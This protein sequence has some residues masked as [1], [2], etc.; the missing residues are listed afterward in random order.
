MDQADFFLPPGKT[1]ECVWLRADLRLVRAAN[2]SPFTGAGTNSYLIGRGD[3][4]LVDPGPDLPAHAAALQA[5]LTPGERIRHVLVTHAHADHSA[6]ATAITA[7]TGAE[8][9]AFGDAH[10]GRSPRMT[11]FADVAGIGGGEGVDLTFQPDRCL[12]DGEVVATDAGPVT[13]LHM[14]GHMS[15]HLCFDW[16]GCL[17]TGDHVMGWSSSIVSPPDGDMAQYRASLRRLMAWNGALGLPG[18]GAPI[19]DLKGRCDAL[20]RHR[21]GREAQILTALGPEGQT[22]AALTARIYAETPSALWPAAARNLL[23]HLIDLS[24]RGFVRADPD[25]HP[26]ATFTATRTSARQ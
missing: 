10:A 15:N 3:V 16:K 2:A 4:V 19:A 1:G 21:D 25:L 22:L 13:A 23:A 26:D 7:T 9:L 5:A 20:L 14:P 24:D 8:L 12:V 17:F 18:H 6:L 11:R